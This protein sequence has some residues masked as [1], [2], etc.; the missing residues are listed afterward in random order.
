MGSGYYTSQPTP[1]VG[2]PEDA[3][4]THCSWRFGGLS[5]VV[6]SPVQPSPEEYKRVCKTC[7]PS[8]RRRLREEVVARAVATAPQGQ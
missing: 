6:L 7:A 4:M 5:G 1:M 3:K 8:I 2:L